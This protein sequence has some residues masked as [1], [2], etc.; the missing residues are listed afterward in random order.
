MKNK[1]G[2]IKGQG[3]GGK[4]A[5]DQLK[6]MVRRMEFGWLIGRCEDVRHVFQVW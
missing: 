4:V 3:L 6:G 1:V 5:S 2:C